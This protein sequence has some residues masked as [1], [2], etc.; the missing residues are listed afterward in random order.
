MSETKSS[1]AGAVTVFMEWRPPRRFRCHV[2]NG[3]RFTSTD[4]LVDA[5]V[6]VECPQP[7]EARDE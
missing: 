5:G 3:R 7:Q 4:E 2:I 1:A 6:L